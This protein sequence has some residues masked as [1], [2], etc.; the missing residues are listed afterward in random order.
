LETLGEPSLEATIAQAGRE[1]VDAAIDACEAADALAA[2]LTH[3]LATDADWRD[4]L[5]LAGLPTPKTTIAELLADA[6]LVRLQ[7]LAPHI[8]PRI[9]DVAGRARAAIARYARPSAGTANALADALAGIVKD[10]QAG[11]S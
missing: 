9:S 8:P 2:I 3:V 11:A 1:V 10:R 7:V 6:V 5:R 4:L